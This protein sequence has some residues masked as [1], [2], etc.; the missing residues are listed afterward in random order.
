MESPT[1]TP[2]S[3]NGDDSNEESETPQFDAPDDGVQ[4]FAPDDEEMFIKKFWNLVTKVAIYDGGSDDEED[5]RKELGVPP[6]YPLTNY[7]EGED[8]DTLWEKALDEVGRDADY[9]EKSDFVE[10]RRLDELRPDNEAAREMAAGVYSFLKSRQQQDIVVFVV[11]QWFGKEEFGEWEAFFYGTYKG[12]TKSGEAY[13]VED[14]LPFKER[15]EDEYFKRGDRVDFQTLPRSMVEVFKVEE[16]ES[17]EALILDSN[18]VQRGRPSNADVT[19]EYLDMKGRKYL[20]SVL[21]WPAPFGDTE[22]MSNEIR[23]TVKSF[24]KSDIHW[25]FDEKNDKKWRID[26]DATPRVLS[27]IVDK[28]YSVAVEPRAEARLIESGEVSIPLFRD[29]FSDYTPSES[30]SVPDTEADES[31][32]D[33]GGEN[34]D[35]D[36]DELSASM[37]KQVDV[38]MDMVFEGTAEVS[39]KAACALAAAKYSDDDETITE[40]IARAVAATRG[41][42]IDDV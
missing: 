5:P 21:E 42:D 32:E 28:G 24:D 39:L 40:D 41:Y 18:G 19:V 20:K 7:P 3:S 11:P 6:K 31:E 34:P 2:N 9:S 14:I 35:I 12:L 17:T 10:E 27:A 15:N 33:E 25:S 4:R 23:E 1:F 8:H 16:P 13:K 30:I 29:Y 26:A 38:V 36:P 22:E 37:E